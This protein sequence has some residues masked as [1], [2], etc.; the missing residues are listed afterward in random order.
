MQNQNIKVQ[1]DRNSKSANSKIRKNIIQLQFR[2]N[3]LKKTSAS[4]PLFSKNSALAYHERSLH[5][6]LWI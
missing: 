1:Y 4:V 2:A 3:L 6:I 5:N